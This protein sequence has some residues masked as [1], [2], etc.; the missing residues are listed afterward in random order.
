MYHFQ[1]WGKQGFF[2]G[3]HK[4]HLS[5][6]ER[7]LDETELSKKLIEI[8]ES[9]DKDETLKRLRSALAKNTETK[10]FND[11]IECL[12]PTHV[13]LL[14][15]KIKPENHK[16]FKKQLWSHYI[17]NNPEVKRY[18][19]FYTETRDEVTEIERSAGAK[20]S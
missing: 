15:E 7:S 4:V 1:L 10:A 8:N 17:R 13:E 3:G 12:S 16:I 19:E 11:Y 2:K 9:I 6:Y 5:G 20:S 18:I 14:L